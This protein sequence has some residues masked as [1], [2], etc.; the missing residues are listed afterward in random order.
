MVVR[1]QTCPKI[2]ELYRALG[3][4]SKVHHENKGLKKHHL[5]LQNRV[6]WVAS[7]PATKT[8]DI[9]CKFIFAV[10]QTSFQMHFL[11]FAC[12][13]LSYPDIFGEDIPWKSAGLWPFIFLQSWSIPNFQG[14]RVLR[15]NPE[16][17]ITFRWS[18]SPL[19]LWWWTTAVFGDVF[20]G[21]SY[22]PFWRG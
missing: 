12:I 20:L 14:L 22:Y 11:I 7:P 18:I 9:H 4:M 3:W 5:K 15:W 13:S 21:G 16:E 1:K 19:L 6:W 8:Y 10:I 17:V 2:L